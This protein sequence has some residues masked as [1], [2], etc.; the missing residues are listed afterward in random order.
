[1]SVA[2]HVGRAVRATAGGFPRSFWWLWT[3]TLINRLGLFVYPFLTLYLTAERGYSVAF[4]GLVLAVFGLGGTVGALLGGVLADRIGRRPTMIG[5]QAANASATL[6]LAFVTQPVAVAALAFVF[7][8]G[9]SGSR[10]AVSA[11]V[12]DLVPPQDRVRAF[13]LSYWADN[14][15]FAAAAAAAGFLAHAGYRWLFVGDAS[16]TV[17][18]GVMMA[19]SLKESLPAARPEPGAGDGAAPAG[20]RQVL[21]DGR[22]MLLVV[23]AFAIWSVYYQGPTALPV[24]MAHRGLDASDYGLVMALNGILIVV[25]QMPVA[26]L[27]RN[28]SKAPLL[29]VGVLLIGGGF[30]LTGLAGSVAVFYALTVVIWTFGEMVY[31]P[32]VSAA[33]ADAGPEQARGR[34]QGVFGF[35]TSAASFVAPLANGQVL[36]H[37][38]PSALWAGCAVLGAVTA[39]GFHLALRTPRPVAPAHATAPEALRAQAAGEAAGS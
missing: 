36:Q 17:L 16:T 5:A 23:M 20:L 31:A 37:F 19:V 18:C 22:F 39:V 8:A 4:A 9:V 33:V 28:R 12:T 13:S 38:G 30:G 6:A 34:Y 25:L 24:V 35:G 1:M 7:G 29:V 11:M 2:T 3:S 26:R 15:G 21:R 14:I 32:T 27:L 10:P